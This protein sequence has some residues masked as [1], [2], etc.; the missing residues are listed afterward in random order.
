M[1][2]GVVWWCGG[3]VVWCLWAPLVLLHPRSEVSQSPVV[4]GLTR[5]VGWL[6]VIIVLLC[7]SKHVISQG[8][9]GP[10]IEVLSHICKYGIHADGR[11]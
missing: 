10:G 11:R 3:V 1:W 9:P 5:M 8:G 6:Q 2:C 4:S 7:C